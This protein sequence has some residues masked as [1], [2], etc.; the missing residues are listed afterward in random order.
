MENWYATSSKLFSTYY[1]DTVDGLFP[2]LKV[3][4]DDPRI[5]SVYVVVEIVQFD[6][7]MPESSHK[8]PGHDCYRIVKALGYDHL[9]GKIYWPLST[10][11]VPWNC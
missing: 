4:S 7:S 6:S 5:C 3:P 10:P 11:L 1:A 9:V 2:D 8:G